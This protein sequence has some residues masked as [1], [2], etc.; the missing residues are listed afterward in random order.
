MKPILAFPAPKALEMP[1]SFFESPPLAGSQKN[2]FYNE[3]CW[4]GGD[5]QK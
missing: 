2:D 4:M 3:N 1:K 5:M